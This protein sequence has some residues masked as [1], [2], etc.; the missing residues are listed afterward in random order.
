M[1]GRQDH[2]RPGRLKTAGFLLAPLLLLLTSGCGGDAAKSGSVRVLTYNV[3]GLP[4]GLS[5][6]NPETNHPLISPLLNSY[7]LVLVQEDFGYHEKLA[8]RATHPHQSKT[9]AK[10]PQGKVMTD[11]LNRFSA[12][13]FADHRR[14]AWKSCHGQLDSGSD[15]LAA[16]GFAVAR[17]TLG[18]GLEVHVYN[19]HMDASRGTE[20][21]QARSSQ[22]DQLLADV[23]QRAA[24]QAVIVAGDFNLK[25]DDTRVDDK[26]LFQRLLQKGGLTDACRAVSC[27]DERIDRVLYR[28]A[29][30]L[31]LRAASWRLPQEFVDG[32]GKDLSDHVPVEVVM[33][34]GEVL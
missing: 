26:S 19:L 28:G 15:C 1:I 30:G 12:L 4:A 7:V 29:P 2:R 8:S 16:K 32:A 18:Q 24:G 13:E 27:G 3:A 25:V 5:K 20:D 34:W 6:S 22:V 31:T 10:P 11:G 17:T 21:H 33:E 14:Q 9:M 23:A